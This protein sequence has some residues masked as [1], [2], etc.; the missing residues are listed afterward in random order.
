MPKV[1][2]LI[3][4][5]LMA[6]ATLPALAGHRAKRAYHRVSTSPAVEPVR[7]SLQSTSSS[8]AESGIGGAGTLDSG[9]L[10]FLGPARGGIGH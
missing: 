2:M 9:G 4:A 10:S 3:A 6:G 5:A 1:A 8:A 7:P